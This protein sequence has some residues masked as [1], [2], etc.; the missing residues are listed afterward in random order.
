[1]SMIDLM[2]WPMVDMQTGTCRRSTRGGSLH[3]HGRTTARTAYVRSA[4]LREFLKDQMELV[5]DSEENDDNI[6]ED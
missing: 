4:V 1:M 2:A 3:L 6:F 5:H